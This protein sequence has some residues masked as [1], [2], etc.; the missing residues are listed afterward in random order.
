MYDKR[1]KVAAAVI[2][3]LIFLASLL[4]EKTL[5]GVPAKELR[6]RA[7]S[8]KD[9]KA[10]RLYKLAAHEASAQLFLWLIGGLS[11]AFSIL[12][13]FNA[14]WW[15]G[16][17][18]AVIIVWLTW[19][20]RP[21]TTTDGWLFW[22]TSMLSSL[23]SL[24][25][26][27][28]Q[29]VLIRLAPTSKTHI[30]PR[31]YEKEDLIEFLKA[32]ARQSD[33]RLSEEDLQNAIGVLGFAEKTVVDV[34]LPK[35][36]VKWVAAS[37]SIGPMVMDELHQTGQSRFAVVKEIVKTGDPQVVG[38]LHL[39]DLLDNLEKGGHIRDIM[40]SGAAYI[41]ETQTLPEALDTF[42][43]SNQNLL[44]VKNDFDEIVGVLTTEHVLGQIFSQK[45]AVEVE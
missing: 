26:S 2:L 20:S 42:L 39:Q 7:R 40:Q 9:K 28:L 35:R 36:K 43:Q 5:R 32:Q 14:R 11:A 27:S 8:Q 1:V 24:I 12:I 21:L 4:L 25:V 15:L 45:P 30:Q 33:S 41:D 31:L 6:R 19:A 37:D 23:V 18:A 13:L 38:T 17:L 10:A 3:A 29:P 16:L 22:L 34:M 44:V